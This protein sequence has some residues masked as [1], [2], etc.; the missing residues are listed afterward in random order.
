MLERLCFIIAWTS[1]AS[2]AERTPLSLDQPEVT[3]VA[4][5]LVGNERSFWLGRDRRGHAVFRGDIVI[6]PS[7][8]IVPAGE[9]ERTAG[10]PVLLLCARTLPE[11]AAQL[12][13]EL[14]AEVQVQKQQEGQ[15]DLNQI[16]D[17]LFPEEQRVTIP[18]QQVD[19][20]IYSRNEVTKVH[21]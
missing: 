6:T 21:H 16:F 4:E 12:D 18:L 9:A 13:L 7:G 1:D 5:Q 2:F 11:L 20:G 19:L 10:L 17:G 15:L 3:P 14:V 8:A